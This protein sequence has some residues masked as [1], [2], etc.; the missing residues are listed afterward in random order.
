MHNSPEQEGV[1]EWLN[2][3][4]LEHMHA[5][6]IVTGLPKFFVSEAVK[7]AAWLKDRVST[8]ALVKK[9][10]CGAAMGNKPDLYNIHE[11]RSKAWV[12]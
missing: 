2:R 5:M 9:T 10:P 8:Q 1:V 11:F 3:I 4:L 12:C 7:H 6:L